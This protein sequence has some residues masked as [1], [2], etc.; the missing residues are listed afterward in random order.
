LYLAEIYCIVVTLEYGALLAFRE[1]AGAEEMRMGKGFTCPMGDDRM[2]GP[3]C[4]ADDE[5]IDR[6]LES[7]VSSVKDFTESQHEVID[8]LTRIGSALSAEHNLERLLEMIV[9]EARKFTSADGGTLYIVDEDEKHLH[10][11]IVQNDSLKVRMGGTAGKIIWKPVALYNDDGSPNH[12]N[13]SSYAAI[14]G[15]VVNIPDVYHA[16]DFDFEGTRTFDASTGYRST[17]ML[18]VP[19]HD[20][21][22]NVIGVLQLLNALDSSGKVI[23]FS[24]ESRRLTESLASQAAV[25]LVNNRLIWD[26]ENLFESFIKT[27]AHAVDEKSPYTGSHGRRVVDITMR[28]AKKINDMNEGPFSAVHF[29]DDQMNEL[30]IAAW[31]HDVGK[32]AVPEYVMDKSTKLQALFDR[33]EMVKTRFEVLKKDL[34]IQ[35]LKSGMKAKKAGQGGNG[36][37]LIEEMKNV[38]EDY[39]FIETVNSG[40]EFMSDDKI[41]RVKAIAEKTWTL[42]EER[43]P[44]ITDEETENL[45]VR[46]GTLT[47]EER[48]T[49]NNHAA[50]T[51]EILSQVPFPRKMKNVPWYA[52]T[53]HEYL[54]GSGYPKGLKGDEIPLQSRIL[55]VADVFEALT[56]ADRPYRKGNTVSQAI[57]ILGFMVKDG[58]LD[59]DLFELSVNEKVFLEYAKTELSPSQIDME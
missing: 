3:V 30:R 42:G 51:Y 7:I 10:F 53:H 27:I 25:A 40:S 52:S 24:A 17:S 14:S 6:L 36:S 47:K 11:E 34:E 41:A 44:L 2:R 45:S 58:Q 38:E 48:D 46:K 23:S 39:A 21:E 50:L 35:R 29:N 37:A 56:A 13:V 20:H 18:V 31:L 4:Y 8:R 22:R 54:N 16:K 32:I 19:M 5:S 57:K 33:I 15:E 28:I 59:K 9:D 55:T 49:I 1:N 43:I 26:L 12:A